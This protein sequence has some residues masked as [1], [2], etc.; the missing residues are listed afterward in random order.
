MNRSFKGDFE[1]TSVIFG[2]IYNHMLISWNQLSVTVL[3]NIYY[4]ANLHS[5]DRSCSWEDPYAY[6]ELIHIDT[7]AAGLK[8]SI[9]SPL[10]T[11]IYVAR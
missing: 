2:V 9:S 4:E 8:P 11:H 3:D 6:I 10:L 5:Q 7:D 1:A